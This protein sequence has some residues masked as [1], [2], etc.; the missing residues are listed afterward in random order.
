M[1]PARYST[2]VLNKVVVTPG[3]NH[4]KD[5]ISDTGDLVFFF[6]LIQGNYRW[7]SKVRPDNNSVVVDRSVDKT[8]SIRKCPKLTGGNEAMKINIGSM[9][10]KRAR[11]LVTGKELVT[12]KERLMY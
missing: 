8:G 11:R 1:M 9:L 4:Q 7:I 2:A 5:Q 6:D 3:K 12:D 10:A